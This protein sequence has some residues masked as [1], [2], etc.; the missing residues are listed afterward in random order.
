MVLIGGLKS[1][2]GA[3][4][5]QMASTPWRWLSEKT[6]RGESGAWFGNG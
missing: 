6:P 2:S 1:A 3:Q 4:P 5:A